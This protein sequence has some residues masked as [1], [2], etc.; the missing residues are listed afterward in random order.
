MATIDSLILTEPG[1]G[2]AAPSAPVSPDPGRAV[3]VTPRP[4]RSLAELDPES[5]R[6]LGPEEL[7]ELAAD[8][9]RLLV[10]T[11][12]TTGGHLGSNLGVVELTLALHR[13]FRSPD[14]AIVWDTGHQ[15]YVH[16]LVTGRAGV[17]AT[18]RQ[19]GGLSGYPN[20]SESIH[21]L[22]ENSHASTGLSYAYGLAAARRLA[23]DP[24][25]VVAVVGD[26]SLT[27]GLAFEALNN[28]GVTQTPMVIVLN[29]NGRSYAPT[30]S[31]LTT[32]PGGGG[33][34]GG[35]GPATFFESLGI[36]YLGPVDG[37]NVAAL[38][39]ALSV[40][41]ATLGPVV[42]HVH[43]VKGRGYR[44]AEQDPEKCL[45][46]VGPFDPV[47]GASRRPRSSSYTE[48][49]SRAVIEAAERNP[50]VV[51]L[52]A[53]M[54]GPTGLLG[55]QARFPDRYFDVGIA[56]QHAVTTATGMALGGLRP[57]V[58]IYSTFL[59]RA[60]DQLLFDV[61][62]HRA[63]IVFCIDRAGVTGDDGPS[64]HGIF[65]LVLLTKVP[66][67][68]VFAPSS[69]P[70]LGVMLN[71]AL[72]LP[73]PSAIRWPKTEAPT[74]G[75][76]HGLSA[77]RLQSAPDRGR[78]GSG[79]R[80]DVCLLGVGKMVAACQEAADRLEGRGL[81]VTVW[82]VRV[83]SPL[84]ASMVEDAARH[85]L[86]LT[87]EDGIADGGVGASIATAVGRTARGR[88]MVGDP[89][90]FTLTQGLPSAFL[91]HGRPADLLAEAGLDGA[92]LEAAVLRALPLCPAPT[93]G[94]GPG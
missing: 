51:A 25:R 92:G 68:T 14:D 48:A 17:F 13:A 42:V 90:P 1:I 58:A 84:D 94:P 60:W 2:L 66:G 39:D 28:I 46:D 64:H 78:G 49:F 67:L 44:P 73:G 8:I 93:T 89:G 83:A 85:S 72:T 12:A 61:A 21:D 82:D 18:L 24:H 53:A 54:G 36:S 59:N 43:T 10:S 6:D 45:H 16:K 80:P 31:R 22:V 55:F 19:A 38:D 77:R 20:R 79:H 57:V 81:G 71:E 86:V 15:A 3:P 29:D 62:L 50:S 87:A 69:Y 11:L 75:V 88:A 33:V 76:G 52:T 7:V 23:G 5:L 4:A 74:V 56:E 27:G 65:D 9:R 91:P 26:G 35:A 41:D 47:T 70:E 37:H 40:A 32:A 34:H 30:V 63:P